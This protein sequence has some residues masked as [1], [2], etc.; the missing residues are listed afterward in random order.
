[1]T[2]DIAGNDVVKAALLDVVDSLIRTSASPPVMG[3]AWLSTPAGVGAVA[4]G[5]AEVSLETKMEE[6]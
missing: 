4:R 5:A 1:V 3:T 6:N 2:L